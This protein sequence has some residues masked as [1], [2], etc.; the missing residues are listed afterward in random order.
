MVALVNGSGT[1]KYR[2]VMDVGCDGKEERVV[3]IGTTNEAAFLTLMCFTIT[4]QIAL[5]LGSYSGLSL[6]IFSN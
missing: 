5:S 6:P 2:K 3:A 1:A 4:V